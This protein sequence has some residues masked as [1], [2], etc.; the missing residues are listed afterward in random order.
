MNDKSGCLLYIAIYLGIPIIF[1]IVDW[2]QKHT[3][4]YWE[5]KVSSLENELASRLN[6]PDYVRYWAFENAQ[7]ACTEEYKKA[8]QSGIGMYFDYNACLRD[9]TSYNIRLRPHYQAMSKGYGLLRDLKEIEEELTEAR[10]ELH[11]VSKVK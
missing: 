10:R 8:N 11:R 1:F 7:S 3:V 2:S 5:A 6:N 4:E 9:K